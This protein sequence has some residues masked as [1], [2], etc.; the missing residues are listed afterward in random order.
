MIIIIVTLTDILIIPFNFN[1]Y[2]FSVTAFASCLIFTTRGPII[3]GTFK[4][5]RATA[6][7]MICVLKK[8]VAGLC[9]S[10][11]KFKLIRDTTNASLTI[12]PTPY[13]KLSVQLLP[14]TVL[15]ILN[16]PFTCNLTSANTPSRSVSSLCLAICCVM[17]GVMIRC[18]L[19]ITT[20]SCSPIINIVNIEAVMMCSTIIYTT[21]IAV[22]NSRVKIDCVF[23]ITYS[24]IFPVEIIGITCTISVM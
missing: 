12:A 24:T 21:T 7:V 10:L 15:R 14:C 9:L 13:V 1:V 23:M 4:H 22:I 3:I 18:Y 8:W 19:I 6:I 11:L 17:Y 16:V 5:I 20:F 2:S